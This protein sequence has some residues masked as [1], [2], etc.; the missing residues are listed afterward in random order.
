MGNTF[1]F[2]HRCGHPIEHTHLTH[3]NAVNLYILW[4]NGREHCWWCLNWAE[5]ADGWALDIVW[6]SIRG[7]CLSNGSHR[8]AWRVQLR[9]MR[10]FEFDCSSV[11]RYLARLDHHWCTRLVEKVIFKKCTW[12]VAKL[13]K[14]WHKCVQTQEVCL[15][16]RVIIFHS[17]GRHTSESKRLHTFDTLDRS[18]LSTH[19]SIRMHK[20]SDNLLKTDS[21]RFRLRT[22]IPVELVVDG[23]GETSVA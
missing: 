5:F 2:F 14:S 20:S 23:D 15:P 11:G 16:L 9:D 6:T 7:L 1:F 8:W 21:G 12:L 19:E 18:Q 22:F 13:D 3:P 17:C 4:L 10:H